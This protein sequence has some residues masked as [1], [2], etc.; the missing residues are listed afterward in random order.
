MNNLFISER[1]LLL[2]DSVALLPHYHV[3]IMFLGYIFAVKV[4]G[5]PIHCS[6]GRRQSGPR[7]FY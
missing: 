3:V 2:C 5:R 1:S 6:R 7:T 4:V